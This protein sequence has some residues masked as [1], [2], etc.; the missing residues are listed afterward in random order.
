MQQLKV[1]L[2]APFSKKIDILIPLQQS[3]APT[4]ALL[5]EPTRGIAPGPHKGLRPMI[6]YILIF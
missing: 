2:M 4:R 5:I 1:E 3:A 6:P